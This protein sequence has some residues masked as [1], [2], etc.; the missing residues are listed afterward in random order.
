MGY[1]A[2]LTLPALVVLLT[3]AGAVEAL[4]G[5]R[6]RRR[7]DGPAHHLVAQVS[8]DGLGMAL[9]PSTRH[10]REHDD[11]QRLIRDQEG[12]GAPPRSRVDL[13]TGAARLVLPHHLAPS[14][15]PTSEP[16][17]PARRTSGGDRPSTTPTPGGDHQPALGS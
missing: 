3:V 11:V 15:P 1:F 5:R 16:A 17:E 9:A 13:D 12:E 7:G 8:F 10:K 14:V 6:H 4:I 2:A